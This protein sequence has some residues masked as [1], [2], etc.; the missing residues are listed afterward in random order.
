MEVPLMDVY[1][2]SKDFCEKRLHAIESLLKDKDLNADVVY[3][4]NKERKLL[5]ELKIPGNERL[6]A[7]TSLFLISQEIHRLS[8]EIRNGGRDE[9]SKDSIRFNEGSLLIKL[10]EAKKIEELLGNDRLVDEPALIELSKIDVDRIFD[11]NS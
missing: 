5:R 9:Q 8:D 11:P 7:I 6:Q 10:H 3:S 2:L 4:L 1:E